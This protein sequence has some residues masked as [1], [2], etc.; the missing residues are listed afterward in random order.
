[1]GRIKDE[2]EP[3]ALVLFLVSSGIAIGLGAA[4]FFAGSAG[5]AYGAGAATTVCL[6]LSVIYRAY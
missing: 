1:M 5:C 6:V 3:V 2:Y 4:A